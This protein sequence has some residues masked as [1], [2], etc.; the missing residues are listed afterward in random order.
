[1]V[2]YTYDSSLNAKMI[3]I[4]TP[5]AGAHVAFCERGRKEGDRGRARQ[6]KPR[7]RG[8][9]AVRRIF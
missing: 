8:A 5:Q 1:M 4:P 7:A 6:E 9:A 2:G 3:E